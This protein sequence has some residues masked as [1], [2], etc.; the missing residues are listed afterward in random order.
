[1]VKTSLVNSSC[2]LLMY[3]LRGGSSDFRICLW[4][5]IAESTP[6]LSTQ[7][8]DCRISTSSSKSSIEL[9]SPLLVPGA[10]K[11]TRNVVATGY[12]E[13]CAP[14]SSLPTLARSKGELMRKM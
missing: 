7:K 5:L 12:S 8:G 10:P 13:Q 2:N 14:L 9:L 4:Y 11:M 3:I 6:L 1:M